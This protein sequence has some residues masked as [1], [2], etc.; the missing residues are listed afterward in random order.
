MS[1]IILECGSGNTVKDADTV[2]ALIDGAI[3]RDTGKHDIVFK[4]QL[5]KAEPP[6]VPLDRH[7]FEFAYKYGT[8][9]GYPVTASVFDYDSLLYLEGFDIPF[10]KIANNPKLY[11]LGKLT[12]RPVIAS[13]DR[14]EW[15]APIWRWGYPLCC[16]SKY[17]ATENDY[18]FYDLQLGM[19]FSDH[20]VGLEMYNKY[21]PAV[22]EKHYVVEHDDS[23]DG[24]A[25]A[26]TPDEL[27]EVL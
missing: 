10:V 13:G 1:L 5:F 15:L 27:K 22:W 18:L 11:W 19:G 21:Q 8:E 2:R 24:G 26:I 23:P 4:F 7:L 14:I 3:Q 25:F 20:T 12:S 17:P 6:N 9:K 16:A